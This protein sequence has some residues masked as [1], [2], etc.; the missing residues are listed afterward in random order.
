MADVGHDLVTVA[1]GGLEGVSLATVDPVA[2]MLAI[3][4]P[5]AL[6][7]HQPP[8]GTARFVIDPADSINAALT[9]IIT[10]DASMRI[11]REF[12]RRAALK[13]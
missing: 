9:H 7:G 1:A 8:V 4:H 2:E 10:P 12:F 3:D 11:T 6:D 5:A 13:L